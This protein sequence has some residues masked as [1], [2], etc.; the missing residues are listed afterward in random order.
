[1]KLECI[2][3]GALNVDK[4]YQVERIAKPGEESFIIGCEEHLG[5]SSANTMV[6]LSR[7]G[8]R[9]G[10]IGKIANDDNGKLHLNSFINECIDIGGVV[11]AG[12]GRSGVVM[13]FVDQHGERTLY[14]DPGA[15]DTLDFTELNLDYAADS[16][17]LHLTSFVG[18]RPFITQR[19]LLE[20]LPSIQL[21][22]DPGE[23][24]VRK[25]MQTI[26]PFLKRSYVVFPNKNELS[27]L[28]NEKIEE[29]AKILIKEG[30]E[31]VA[32][33]L[34]EKGCFVTDGKESFSVPAIKTKVVDATGAGDAFC[35]GFLHG[36]LERK[37]I[38]YCASLGNIVASKKLLK[39]GARDGL[40]YLRDLN[41]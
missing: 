13:G 4:L 12:Y 23:L 28:T 3:F 34:G 2:G 17:F 7:L 10:Y 18:E 33:K 35:A 29:G 40:P 24:Y 36:I 41:V 32:V 16:T 19:K 6:G 11:K 1:M 21:S 37:D 30:A 15:N 39:L 25:G 20:A 27:L 9:V 38:H 5:G 8:H 26:R 31:I 22:F 14:V